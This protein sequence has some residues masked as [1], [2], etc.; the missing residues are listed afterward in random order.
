MRPVTILLLLGCALIAHGFQIAP[1]SSRVTL[2]ATNHGASTILFMAPADDDN[3]DEP[4]DVNV[5]IVDD[6][7]PVTLTVIGLAA[8]AI[9][10]F[11]FA[12]MGDAGVGGIVARIINAA[13][14]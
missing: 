5:N 8:I 3:N 2:T 6:V 9:N 7:D 11:V 12:N 14:S 13:R 10:F 1:V 4:P